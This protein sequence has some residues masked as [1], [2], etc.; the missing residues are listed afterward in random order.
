[1]HFAHFLSSP[2]L[3]L[4]LFL[5]LICLLLIRFPSIFVSITLGPF[6]LI[7]ANRLLIERDSL[8]CF[9]FVSSR[10][11]LSLFSFSCP[12]PHFLRL[13]RSYWFGRPHFRKTIKSTIKPQLNLRH[14]FSSS[15]TFLFD[16][17]DSLVCSSPLPLS[18]CQPQFR[19]NS[20]CRKKSANSTRPKDD[21]YLKLDLKLE[22][23]VFCTIQSPPP[24]PILSHHSCPRAFT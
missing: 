10:H 14:F 11:S 18:T 2:S 1:V 9:P 13:L 20:F 21:F 6:N 19:Q 8:D 24:P 3:F 12:L 7:C 22:R 16:R 4:S 5:S 17:Q 15:F 23:H